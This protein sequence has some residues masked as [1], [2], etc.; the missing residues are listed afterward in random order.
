MREV[1]QKFEKIG[2]IVSKR[3]IVCKEDFVSKYT[4]STIQ[5]YKFRNGWRYKIDN[6]LHRE[7]DD[8]NYQFNKSKSQN[9]VEL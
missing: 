8:N 9:N 7:F 1:Y 4:I 3:R 6:N 5:S 2:L